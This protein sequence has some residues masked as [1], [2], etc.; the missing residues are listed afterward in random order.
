MTEFKVG[1]RVMVAR[2][3]RHS[4]DDHGCDWLPQMDGMVGKE[5][6]IEEI[7][8]HGNY[9]LGGFYFPPA[10][11]R[12]V[13]RSPAARILFEK[14]LVNGTKCR[15]ITGFEGILGSDELP[16]KYTEGVP[17]FDLYKASA[18]HYEFDGYGMRW[19]S[20]DGIVS[21]VSY[22]IPSDSDPVVALGPFPVHVLTIGDIYPEATYHAILTWLKRAGSRLAKIRQ[23]EREAWSGP[24]ADEI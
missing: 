15:R 9:R 14:I 16:G 13:S 23:Q 10:V 5:Y 8:E 22:N 20:L 11:L 2:K 17:S 3:L 4:E 21:A 18:S 7:S 24:G 19:K 12:R 6:I 1:D